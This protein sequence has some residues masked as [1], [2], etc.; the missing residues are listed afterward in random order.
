MMAFSWAFRYCSRD[1]ASCLDAQVMSACLESS[2][3]RLHIYPLITLVLVIL[4]GSFFFG[5]FLLKSFMEW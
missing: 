2:T 3:N 1:G 5:T 4:L